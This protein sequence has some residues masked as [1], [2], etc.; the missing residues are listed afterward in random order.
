MKGGSD[1]TMAPSEQSA[2]ASVVSCEPSPDGKLQAE[3]AD[4]PQT[5]LRKRFT[6][7]STIAFGFTTMNSW[8][9][10]ASG[11]A[12]PLSC[13][14]GPTLIYGLLVGGII[15]AILA[16]GYAELASAFPSAGGQYHI[17]YMTFPAPTRRFAA[18]FTGWMSILYTMGATAS[19]S[20]FVAQSILNL[21]TLWNESYVAHSW[22]V[23]LVH[24]CLC[25]IAFLAASRFPASIGSIGVSVFWL[26][27]IGFIASL[28]TLLAVQE[29][30]QPSKFVFTEFTNVSGWTDGWAAMIGLASCLWAYC[31][32]DA[33]SHLSEEV[34]NPSR[35]IPIAIG[36]TIILGI[37]SVIAWNIGLM[38]V[39]KDVQKLIASGAPI[40]EV[41]NQ[42]LGSKTATTI[43][44][45]YYILVFYH[46]ILN[47]F[48]FSSRILWSF[49]RDGGVPYSSYV[50]RLRWSNPVRATA[51]MLVLQIIIGILYIAS[52][53]AYSSFINL[54]LFALNI[55]VVLPQTVLLFTGRDSLPKRAF[56]LGRYG[57]VVNA[58]AT[59]FML[60]F[61]V[62]FAFPVARPVT[63]SS[64]NYLVVIFAVSLIFIISSWLL[65]L[66]KRFTG[67]SEGTVHI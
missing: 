47:L 53:T 13:G 52:K 1:H 22:H 37:I 49:A 35:N 4:Y 27:I 50:S 32:I 30:K 64:M 5:H 62:V 12:V 31:G 38:Y 41:Y 8:V 34:D 54:T 67:P 48:V 59:V 40:L 42:A 57:H 66:S 36:A 2:I 7:V 29:V 6:L 26:S 61:S 44:A 60:L 24:I 33:P 10:F 45:V 16:A 17:V 14:A 39:I 11:L 3:H 20:F 21:V 19:C 63:G 28:A 51:I 23:Y 43:W 55:T 65:G 58:M 56:S 46:I 9:A 15:M 25:T 18:F